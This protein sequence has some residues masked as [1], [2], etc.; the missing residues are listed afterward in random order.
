MILKRTLDKVILPGAGM[1]QECN[2]FAHPRLDNFI[3]ISEKASLQQESEAYS[4]NWQDIENIAAANREEMVQILSEKWF[5]LHY[6]IGQSRFMD[7][8]GDGT[9]DKDHVGDYSSAVSKAIIKPDV[10]KSFF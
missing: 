10:G 9:G 5:N 3:M 4:F 2:V 6:R 7:S 8:N 1:S